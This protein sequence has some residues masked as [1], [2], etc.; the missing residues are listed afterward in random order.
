L[1]VEQYRARKQAVI[2]RGSRLL[3]RAAL[4]RCHDKREVWQ[5]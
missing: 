4:Y 3:T 5:W 1:V 2:L